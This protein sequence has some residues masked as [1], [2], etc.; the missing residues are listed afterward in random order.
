M[1]TYEKIFDILNDKGLNKNWLRNNG[2]N[3]RTVDKLI[4]NQDL[5]VS[6]INRLCNLL[7]C[8]PGDILTFTKD[9]EGTYGD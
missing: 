6:T 8:Q 9:E 4:K 7:D 1:I 2:I 5:N 3:P